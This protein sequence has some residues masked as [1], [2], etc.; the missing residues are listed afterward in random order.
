MFD[1]FG[2]SMLPRLF[3]RLTSI[4]V[5]RSSVDDFCQYWILNLFSIPIDIHFVVYLQTMV[6]KLV[7]II[8]LDIIRQELRTLWPLHEKISINSTKEQSQNKWYCV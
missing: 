7:R 2:S 5:A 1:M 4:E 8:N 3:R 6:T